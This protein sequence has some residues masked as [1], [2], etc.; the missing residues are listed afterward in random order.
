M[1]LNQIMYLLFIL[2]SLSLHGSSLKS[3]QERPIIEALGDDFFYLQTQLKRICKNLDELHLALELSPPKLFLTL[4][5][6]IDRV[7]RQKIKTESALRV[8]SE[9]INEEEE[10][11][12]KE[13]LDAFFVRFNY[14][15]SFANLCRWIKRP[16]LQPVNQFTKKAGFQND[17]DNDD[18]WFCKLMKD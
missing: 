3:I 11:Y 17:D 12:R 7:T 4:L 16:I 10:K 15:G 13:E 9:K 5:K 2:S 1:L 18:D 14:V 6:N 8:L